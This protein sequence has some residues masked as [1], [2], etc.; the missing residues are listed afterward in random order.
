MRWFGNVQNKKVSHLPKCLLVCKAVNEKRSAGGQERMWNDVLMG[1]LNRCE[2][3]K[4]WKE[5]AQDK[6]FGD[7]LWWKYLPTSMTT[8]KGR[9]RK[10]RMSEKEERKVYYQSHWP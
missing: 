7:I 6:V 9:R 3:L 2:L 8:W 10:G 4:N 1:D 5:T